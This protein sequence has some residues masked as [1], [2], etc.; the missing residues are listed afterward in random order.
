MH[1]HLRIK[2]KKADAG[3]AFLLDFVGGDGRNRTA[4]LWVINPSVEAGMWVN[5][6]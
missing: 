1:R 6:V 3:S 4:D 5:G 2:S